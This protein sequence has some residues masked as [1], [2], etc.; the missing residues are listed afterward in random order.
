MISFVS[1][2]LR[3]LL[4]YISFFLLLGCM[5]VIGNSSYYFA[6]H[7]NNRSYL[8]VSI[9]VTGIMSIPPSRYYLKISMFNDFDFINIFMQS[10]IL[11]SLIFGIA[12]TIIAF[13]TSSVYLSWSW[14]HIIWKYGVDAVDCRMFTNLPSIWIFIDWPEICNPKKQL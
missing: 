4:D 1:G 13:G 11:K 2:R 10:S 8:F 9:I 14:V 6:Y 7:T 12:I 3:Y 5:W